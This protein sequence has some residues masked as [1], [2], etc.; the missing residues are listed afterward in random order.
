MNIDKCTR[1]I[2]ISGTAMILVGLLGGIL[3][4]MTPHPRLALGAH[5]QFVTNGMLFVLQA[6]VLQIFRPSF[7]TKAAWITVM[8]AFFTWL[9]AISEWLNAWWGTLQ[10]LPLA[11]GQAGATGGTPLQE[12]LVKAPHGLAAIALILSWALVLKGLAARGKTLA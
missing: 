4:P 5:I 8:A 7:G 6:C 3:V 2:L 9:M 1:A 10:T 12:V 11:G